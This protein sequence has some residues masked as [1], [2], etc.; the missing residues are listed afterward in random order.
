MSLESNKKDPANV[1]HSVCFF[2]RPMFEPGPSVEPK[3]IQVPRCSQEES[4]T[5]NAFLSEMNS[6]RANVF[7]RSQRQFTYPNQSQFRAHSMC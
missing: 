3:R 4:K 6:K 7:E 2:R 5:L 1:C